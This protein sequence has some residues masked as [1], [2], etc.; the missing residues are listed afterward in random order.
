MKMSRKKQQ[1]KDV[2][3]ADTKM[4]DLTVGTRDKQLGVYRGNG[5]WVKRN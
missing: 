4:K 3:T 1:D 5:M 2:K